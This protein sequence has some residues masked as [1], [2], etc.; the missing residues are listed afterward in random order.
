MEVQNSLA[1]LIDT[2]ADEAQYDEVVKKILA[3]RVILDSVPTERWEF[4]SY[5]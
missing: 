3:Y 4:A 2:A 5:K 1:N